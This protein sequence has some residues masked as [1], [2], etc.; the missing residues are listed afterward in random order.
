MEKYQNYFTIATLTLCLFIFLRT[1]GTSS[2]LSRIEK[3]IDSLNKKVHQM[4]S[5]SIKQEQM[6]KIIK[7]TPNWKTLEIEELSDKNKVPVN[8]YKNMDK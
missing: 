6:V 2:E 8:Y 3:D 7:E 5:T 4:D 1:C